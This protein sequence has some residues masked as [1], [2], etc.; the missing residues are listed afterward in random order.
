MSQE[1][2]HFLL[3]RKINFFDLPLSVIFAIVVHGSQ[4]KNNGFLQ[5][6]SKSD[7]EDQVVQSL[8]LM[9]EYFKPQRC[10]RGLFKSMAYWDPSFYILPATCHFPS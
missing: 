3:H 9:D 8:Q 6:P 4:D 5:F 1:N 2:Q 10:C 7:L